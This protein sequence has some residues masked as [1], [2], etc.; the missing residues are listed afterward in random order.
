MAVVT[1]KI[2]IVVAVC[3]DCYDISDE[4]A[5][6]AGGENDYVT[7]SAHMLPST[8]YEFKRDPEREDV[9]H[10]RSKEFDIMVPDESF[11]KHFFRF[12]SDEKGE[13]FSRIGEPLYDERLD[14]D[15]RFGTALV[16]CRERYDFEDS[17]IAKDGSEMEVRFSMLP[18]TVYEYAYDYDDE[19]IIH[20]RTAEIDVQIMKKAFLQ[21]FAKFETFG[22]TDRI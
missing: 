9:I 7:F 3:R 12:D 8:V 11:R 20:I 19:N 22:L 2:P 13:K 10:L 5:A 1:K 18:G 15:S 21:H 16:M 14:S 17:Y 6:R 4:F